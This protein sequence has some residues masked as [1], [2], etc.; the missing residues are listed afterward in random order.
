MQ[1]G[2][3]YGAATMGAYVAAAARVNP[4]QSQAANCWPQ[5]MSQ[6]SH[7]LAG[8]IMSPQQSASSSS[9]ADQ[10][11]QHYNSIASTQQQQTVGDKQ[12]VAQ[13]FAHRQLCAHQLAATATSNCSNSNNNNQQQAIVHANALAN[14][15][16]HLRLQPLSQNLVHKRDA[17]QLHHS[18][19]SFARCSAANKQQLINA[20]ANYA[21]SPSQA[22][23]FCCSS[24][25][26]PTSH[27]HRRL[28]NTPDAS[29][30]TN[31]PNSTLSSPAHC[32]RGGL[33]DSTQQNNR[34]QQRS[35][36]I[37]GRVNSLSA[38]LPKRSHLAHLSS[39]TTLNLVPP[40]TNRPSDISS[41][42]NTHF[43]YQ[44][45][46]LNL[47]ELC[48]AATPEVDSLAAG[49]EQQRQPGGNG[50]QLHGGECVANQST[51]TTTYLRNSSSADPLPNSPT[52]SSL[53][54][55]SPPATANQIYSTTH[56]QTTTTINHTAEPS[57]TLGINLEQYISK[58][59]ERERSRVRNVND[60][61]DNLKNSLPLDISK[62]TKRMSK[63][64]ILRMAI[65]YIRDLEGVL[66]CNG[67]Q[68][69]QQ[70]NLQQSFQ[71][72]QQSADY[73][74]L[75]AE[76]Q[77]S[78]N[79]KHHSTSTLN[80]K[81]QMSL[82]MTATT[83]SNNGANN[84]NNNCTNEHR[85]T[86]A[87]RHIVQHDYEAN[88]DDNQFYPKTTDNSLALYGNDMIS[89]ATADNYAHEQY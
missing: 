76:Q 29:M 82:M 84:N 70:D 51:T 3:S 33:S 68:Q 47:A 30:D 38:I 9:S 34:L 43:H 46:R 15:H 45:S 14:D 61:F 49:G 24:N 37:R 62:L 56:T 66:S 52:L 57:S 73:K 65:N 64:E 48:C 2:A 80:I 36:A 53:T 1:G 6:S 26:P 16:H 78:Y 13:R 81:P 39:S 50:L 12:Q 10:I 31:S 69:Q 59:N 17:S 21:A 27:S 40:Q 19:S 77:Q 18:S 83:Q 8:S 5:M 58:R 74:Y 4:M 11:V 86:C 71:Q 85:R 35:S 87:T 28:S 22:G 25:A 23:E 72:Q 41:S 7:H 89:F 67:Q 55:N 60:A 63:V 75:K 54:S 32:F 88:S 20:A 44:R 42:L 79:N